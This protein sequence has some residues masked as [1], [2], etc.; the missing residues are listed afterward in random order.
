MSM[1]AIRDTLSI[2]ALTPTIGAVVGGLRLSEPL[3]EDQRIRLEAALARHHVLFFR[4][5]R[6]TPRQ[7][8]D[9]AAH[10]GE[11]HVH[12][13]YPPHDEAREIM[14]LDTDAIDLR[15][16]ALWHT[17]VTF[18]KAPPMGAVLAARMLPPQGGDTL[19]SSSIAAFQ[20]LSA[21]FRTFLGGLTATHDIAH[22]FPAERFATTAE[23][24]KRLA[25]ARR[26]NPP[27]THPVV[28]THPQ[29]R[30]PGLFVNDG[31]TTRINELSV[32]ES[33]QVLDLLYVHS[34]RPEFVVR[35]TWRDG[36]VAFWDNRCTQHYA[37]DDYRPARRVMHRATIIGD[38]PFWRPT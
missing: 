5:Q 31:F 29:S 8:R 35:W 36:D 16:N 27:V 9:F 28:R 15:D 10:F 21:P 37:T 22:T 34:V 24:Q 32:A 33:R 14:V 25:D 11:L 1:A 18:L 23:A 20:A 38:A 4:D 12:P 19:W 17:D 7:H 30:L 6:L 26:A 13:I 2:T 3:E